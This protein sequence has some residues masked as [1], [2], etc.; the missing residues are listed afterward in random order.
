MAIIALGLHI[1]FGVCGQ[2]NFGM[3]GFYACG[4]YACGLLI[5][6]A[7]LHYFAAMLISLI[8]V[9]IITL[10]LGL[11]VLRL[12]HWVLALGTTA[13]GFVTWLTVKSVAIGFFGGDD[14]IDLPHLTIGNW[15]CG[16]MFFY[17]FIVGW[18]IVCS[19]L[20]HFLGESRTGRALKA[21]RED[22][23]AAGSIG[24]NVDYYIRIAFLLCGL[25]GGLAGILYAQ[26]NRWIA[27]ASF[28][29]DVS[30]F[31]LL[32]VIVGG[33]GYNSGAILGAIIISL[34]PQLLVPLREWQLLFYAFI[35]FLVLRVMSKGIV[36]SLRAKWPWFRTRFSSGQAN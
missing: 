16:A 1:F 23:V 12:R 36:G 18:V 19:L 15:K 5:Q 27:P 24:I 20:S 9:A 35:L 22:E 32:A 28:S 11:A 21:I 29:I 8:L 25:Y 10:I 17:Y 31:A 30:T 13:F 3:N 33:L 6:R 26:W 34:L 14:G 4:A 2:I 7:G